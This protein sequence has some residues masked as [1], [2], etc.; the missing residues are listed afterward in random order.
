MLYLILFLVVDGKRINYDSCIL[1]FIG[2][3]EKHGSNILIL[4]FH[5]LVKDVL[6]HYMQSIFIKGQILYFAIV[7][8]CH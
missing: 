1:G 2:K 3:W 8:L 6:K 5:C 4:F 7:F